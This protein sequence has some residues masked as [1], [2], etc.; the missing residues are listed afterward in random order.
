MNPEQRKFVDIEKIIGE[1]NPRLLKA[2]P[3]F[4][5]RYIKRVL[6]ENDV[7]DFMRRYGHL[8][9]LDFAEAIIKDF[10]ITVRVKGLEHL[11]D[12]KGFYVASNHPLGGLDG[13]ALIY[14]VAQKR[15]DVRFLVNDILMHLKPL[16]TIFIPVNKHGSQHSIQLIEETY[17]SDHAV[18]IFPAGLV[19]RKI[20]G[21]IRDLEWKKSFV[22]KAQ[23]YHKPVVPAFIDGKNSS[24]FYN[25]ALWRKRF[26][27]KANIEMFYLADEM[28]KQRNKTITIIFDQPVPHQAFDKSKSQRDWAQLMR[29]HIYALGENRKGPFTGIHKKD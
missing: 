23:Q 28:Y 29:E 10:N 11:P 24:F 17:K 3:G 16:N 2:L 6:H 4:I 9:G 26:G 1:K 15:K 12:D 7:N 27:I 13:I 14:A 5:L 21:K 18:L 25:L 8:K 20:E 22:S 19:S